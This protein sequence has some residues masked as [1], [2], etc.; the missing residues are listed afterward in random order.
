VVQ[1]DHFSLAIVIGIGDDEWRYS[2]TR[3]LH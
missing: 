2:A 3:A 1:T